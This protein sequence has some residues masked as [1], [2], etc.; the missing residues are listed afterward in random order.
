MFKNFCILVLWTKVAS[1]LEGL[2][3]SS[4]GAYLV[5]D[6]DHRWRQSVGEKVRARALTKQLN[7]VSRSGS[8]ASYNDTSSVVLENTE[9]KYRIYF[10]FLKTK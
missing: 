5:C 2:I 1:A 3:G 6:S 4:C 10:T 8:V 7:E 9:A